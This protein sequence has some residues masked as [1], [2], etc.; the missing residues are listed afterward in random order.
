[1]GLGPVSFHYSP[2]ENGPL[3]YPLGNSPVKPPRY[4][5]VEQVA[6][7]G[8][9][10]ARSTMNPEHKANA[11]SPGGAKDRLS[12]LREIYDRIAA[13]QERS[14][15][16]IAKSGTALACPQGCVS[17]CEGF[18]P[19]VLP[20]EADF[21]AD[22]LLGNRPE[23]AAAFLERGG[24][25]APSPPCPLYEAGRKGGGCGAYPARPLICRLFGFASVRDRE[26]AESY[27]LCRAMGS[28]GGRRSWSGPELERDLGARLLVMP[29]FAAAAVAIAPQEAGDRDLITG[30]LPASLRRASL[31]LR[32]TAL[33]SGDDPGGDEPSTPSPR[34]A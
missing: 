33:E 32:L 29:D 12:R 1:M 34:A 6:R 18:I 19:D 30:I 20:V 14:L 4:A 13:A 9:H 5:V 8:A 25:A 10:S 31:Y 21:L 17:C 2:Y 7:N 27:S 28:M 24:E 16:Q 11:L 15:E 26:G 22:W 23:L 3:R